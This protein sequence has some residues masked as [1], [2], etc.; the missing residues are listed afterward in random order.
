MGS[1]HPP[2]IPILIRILIILIDPLQPAPI[3]P[4]R[5]ERTATFKPSPCTDD[6]Y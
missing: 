6:C 1:G 2:V 3:R 4:G 5:Y